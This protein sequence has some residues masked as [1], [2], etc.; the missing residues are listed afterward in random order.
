MVLTFL[1]TKGLVVFGLVYVNYGRVIVDCPSGCGNAFMVPMGT[2][3]MTCK[4]KNDTGCG[5]D[6]ALVI[7]DNLSEIITE[8]NH[9]P[10]SANRNWYPDNHPVAIRGNIPMGQSVTDLVLEYQM[11]SEEEGS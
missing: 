2:S 7:P 3:S 1:H 4:G 8:L 6:F 10:N 11:M 5:A 9:R